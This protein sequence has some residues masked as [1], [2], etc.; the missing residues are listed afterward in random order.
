[1]PVAARKTRAVLRIWRPVE[2]E[3]GEL[4]GGIVFGEGLQA[5]LPGP[6]QAEGDE[7]EAQQEEARQDQEG[8]DAQVGARPVLA[9]EV[10]GEEEQEQEGGDRGEGRAGQ[11][12]RVARDGGE[13]AGDGVQQSLH[14]SPLA[15][16][17]S[18]GE[19]AAGVQRGG[20]VRIGQFDPRP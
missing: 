1:M 9:H 15:E 14:L 7:G 8:E 20:P 18:L 12:D 17:P 13:E 4:G 10:D 16:G 6:P 11:A 3:H 2:V 19:A 5:A